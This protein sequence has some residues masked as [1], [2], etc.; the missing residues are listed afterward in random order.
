M[1]GISGMTWMAAMTCMTIPERR[2]GTL[3]FKRKG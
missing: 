3:D 2:G 1:I